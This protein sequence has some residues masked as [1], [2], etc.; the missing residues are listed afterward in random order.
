MRSGDAEAGATVAQPRP[1]DPRLPYTVTTAAMTDPW[2]TGTGFAPG[3]V[4]PDLVGPEWDQVIG[5]DRT[6]TCSVPGL[7]VLFHYGGP[8]GPADAVRY[9]AG[10]G[11]RVFSAGS[12]Q[13]V[14][15]LDDYGTGIY[16]HAS[17]A[18]PRSSASL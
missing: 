14:W 1:S 17:P 3:D 2:F 15:G 10:S 11:A 5:P 12:L 8:P 9:T 7:T 13:F 16:G 6:P 4:L 18:D